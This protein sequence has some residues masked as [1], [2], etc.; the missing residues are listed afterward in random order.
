MSLGLIKV[1]FRYKDYWIAPIWKSRDTLS[2]IDGLK[3]VTPHF[4]DTINVVD[5]PAKPWKD[6]ASFRFIGREIGAE[7]DV[8]YEVTSCEETKEVSD[9][10]LKEIN[11]RAE[12]LYW[13]SFPN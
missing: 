8:Y 1:P 13:N 5:Y 12:Y 10:L 6:V 3:V 7:Y 9:E 11:V 2:Y 4:C